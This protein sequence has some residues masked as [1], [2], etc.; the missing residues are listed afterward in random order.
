VPLPSMPEPQS[1]DLG[2]PVGIA[3]GEASDRQVPLAVAYVDE[4]G[5][6]HL[7]PRGTVQVSTSDQLALW[8]RSPGLVD[9][10]TA[11]PYVALLYQNIPDRTFYQFSGRARP[12]DDEAFRTRVYDS[13][14]AHEQAQDPNRRGTAVLIDIDTVR[15]L[16]PDG[17]VVMSRDRATT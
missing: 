8:A 9:A 7:S 2:G 13:S 14:P 11:N 3:I 12:I 6:P 16:G 10:I 5:R 17:M 4:T 1:V 15:G